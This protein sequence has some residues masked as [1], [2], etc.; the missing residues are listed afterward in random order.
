METVD[1]NV[2]LASSKAKLQS[3]IE[4]QGAHPDGVFIMFHRASDDFPLM[5]KPYKWTSYKNETPEGIVVVSGGKVLVVALQDSPSTMLWSSAAVSGG[6][7]TTTDRLV[8]FDDWG[9]KTSTAAQVKHAECKEAAYAPGYCNAY[10]V[11]N[12]NGKGL[13][14]GKWWLPSVAEMMLIYANMVAI[15]E[16]IATVGGQPLK[17]SAYW[18][19]TEGGSTNAWN[20]YLSLGHTG[21]WGSK[22][23]RRYYVRPVSAFIS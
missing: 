8:A 16:A 12:A 17:E 4:P 10:S 13:T 7:K 2:A 18:T 5:V 3:I 15:N 11:P 19:S 6:G 14:A 9:G 21:N 23:E 20:F 22:T 1:I